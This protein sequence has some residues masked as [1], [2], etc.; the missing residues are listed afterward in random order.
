MPRS[1]YGPAN[2]LVCATT[3][4]AVVCDLAEQ[5]A[6]EARDDE[7]ALGDRDGPRRKIHDLV[8]RVG[9]GKVLF[10]Q[11]EVRNIHWQQTHI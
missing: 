4:T 11:L 1:V 3:I 9:I 10:T 2:V 7:R 6:I 5:A 8:S